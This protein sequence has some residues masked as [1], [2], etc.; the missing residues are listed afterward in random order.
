MD[1]IQFYGKG[2]RGAMLAVCIPYDEQPHDRGNGQ[3]IAIPGGSKEAVD[4]LHAKA[5]ELGAS[6]E[7]APGDRIP[8][9][10]YGGCVR[11]LDDNK[12]CFMDM[13]LG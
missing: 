5:L 11:D 10:F 1:R 9:V 13:K 3:M 2:D 12:L 7:G 4:A 6:D 8:D